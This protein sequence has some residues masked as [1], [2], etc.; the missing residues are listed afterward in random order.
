M[1]GGD[2]SSILG[3]PITS[4]TLS[5]RAVGLE[6]LPDD[7]QISLEAKVAAFKHHGDSQSMS[8]LKRRN[9]VV[10]QGGLS[11]LGLTNGE[12]DGSVGSPLI[13]VFQSS[14]QVGGS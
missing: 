13:K 10:I 12:G 14:S 4:K 2:L 5:R 1:P 8:P 9:K 6:P 7:H 3:T 11:K